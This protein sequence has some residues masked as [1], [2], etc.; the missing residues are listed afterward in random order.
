SRRSDMSKYGDV[1]KAIDAER[2]ELSQGDISAAARPATACWLSHRD[3]HGL[4]WLLLDMPGSSANL[5][6]EQVLLELN[7][8]IQRIEAE[9]PKAVVIRSA[10][11]NGFI[12]GADVNQFRGS[13]DAK[14]LEARLA[15]AHAIVD[16][17]E[18][19]PIPTIAV[20]HG[21]CLGGGL[22]LALA[23]RY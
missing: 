2:L 12:A 6:K 23:C 4:E 10:K 21:F 1:L 5:L 8:Q 18:K 3:G 16:R 14:A 11:R 19:L 7:Q 20:I 13:M 17:L 22:E 15:D 9:R